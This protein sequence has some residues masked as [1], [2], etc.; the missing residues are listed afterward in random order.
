MHMQF[1][2]IMSL[3]YDNK[4]S[5]DCCSR[6]V[7]ITKPR[8]IGTVNVTLAVLDLTSISNVTSRRY[9]KPLCHMGS[10]WVSALQA[11]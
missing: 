7:I 11:W 8:V 1:D 4:T 2:M 10:T 5:P 6:V 3:C 9:P